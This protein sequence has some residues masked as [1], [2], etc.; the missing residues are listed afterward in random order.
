MATLYP[1]SAGSTLPAGAEAEAGA[2]AL[3]STSACLRRLQQVMQAEIPLTRAIGIQLIAYDR[4]CLT[5]GAPLAQNVNDKGT[6]FSGSLNA[7][8]TLAGWGLLWLL[9]DEYKLSGTIA[10]Q[11]STIHYMRPVR[12]DFSARCHRPA[13]IEL[14]QFR[15]TMQKRGRARLTDEA[16]VWEQNI[17][18]VMFSGRYVVDLHQPWKK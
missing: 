17:A 10:I 6:V 9:L 4:E 2:D 14:D 13:S 18:L 5:L 11:D 12:Q 1:S 8:A 3:E 16:G 7:V 15:S